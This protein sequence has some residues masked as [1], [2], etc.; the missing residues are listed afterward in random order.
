MIA[1]DNGAVQVVAGPL[2]EVDRV[3]KRARAKGI[4][5]GRLRVSHAFHSPAV[6]A[7]EPVLAR[8][9][10][11]LAVAALPGRVYSTVTGRELTAADDIRALLARQLTAPVRF[12]QALE[13]LAAD[14]DLL[15]E[16]G[17]GHTLTAMAQSITDVPVRTLDAGAGSAAALGDATAALFAVGAVSDLTALFAE[18]FHRPFD[19]WREP[20]FLANPCESAPTDGLDRRFGRSAA[21]AAGPV[22]ADT[23]APAA[24]TPPGADSDVPS[25]VR[26]LIADALE[27]PPM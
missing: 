19:L 21:V 11:D 1:A 27:L 23:A 14:C 5:A 4:T 24:E 16:A 2:T 18:R 7:A 22:A 25:V 9:L 10:A 6:A 3:V 26:G 17:P 13:L 12:R 20:E 8:H 15:V